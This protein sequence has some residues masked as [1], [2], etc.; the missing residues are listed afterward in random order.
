[1]RRRVFLAG[2]IV[3]VVATPRVARAE[4]VG[5]IWRIGASATHAR[6]LSYGTR[7]PQLGSRGSA[8]PANEPK[9][10]AARTF[11]LFLPNYG[12]LADRDVY[13]R[14]I[15][16]GERAEAEGIATLIPSQSAT[17]EDLLLAH[18]PEYVQALRSGQ[19]ADLASQELP[20]RTRRPA[21]FAGPSKRAPQRAG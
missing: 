4:Q 1:V 21:L 17:V 7:G 15:V 8:V 2:S 14:H 9:S 13:R 18:T 12:P 3:G 5:K 6:V 20:G 16:A 11:R 10:L 19:P